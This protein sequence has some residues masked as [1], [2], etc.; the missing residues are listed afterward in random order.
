MTAGTVAP[1]GFR[2]FFESSSPGMLA[3]ALALTGNRHDAEDAVQ[4]AYAEALRRWDTVGGY[5][6][7]DA[8]V[9]LVV[10]QRCWKA[11]RRWRRSSSLDSLELAAWRTNSSTERA[12]EALIALGAL[13]A[14]R[15]RQRMVMGLHLLHGMT[16]REIAD[17]LGMTDNAVRQ[18][19][20]KARVRLSKE[21]A[22][23]R[24]G[25]LSPTE[26]AVEERSTA[27]DRA[28]RTMQWLADTLH[29]TEDWLRAG[30]EENDRGRRRV[31]GEILARWSR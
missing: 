24:L 23:T 4:E 10:R 11:A 20:L 31:L 16:S 6:A 19:L 18:S 2:E 3:R 5:D 9:Y 25:H 1:A 13:A 29:A 8:W 26:R 21:L 12:A 7:P 14:L 22:A 28:T 15:G 17:E 30:I 27:L